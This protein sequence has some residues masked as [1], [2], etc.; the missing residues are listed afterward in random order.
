MRAS[1]TLHQQIGYAGWL[2]TNAQYQGEKSALRRRWLELSTPVPLPFL[3]NLHDGPA[4]AVSVEQVRGSIPLDAATSGFINDLGAFLRR[5]DIAQLVTWDLPLAQGPLS[6]ATLGLARGLLG[7]DQLVNT[8]PTWTDAPSHIDAR[9]DI[10]E[11]QQ[12]GAR[13]RGHTEDYPL[14]NL[15]PRAN[16]VSTLETAFRMWV[17]EVTVRRRYG[18]PRG[19][20]SRL[21]G[22]FTCLFE[23][24][25]DRVNQ[26]RRCYAAFLTLDPG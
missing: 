25:L 20:V 24:G 19:L 21:E 22:A 4:L 6:A 9:Q 16:Q 2:T 14:T 13:Q 10:R 17:I 11:T 26:V 18:S 3:A 5:W 15:G 1:N 7:P 8:S 12:L 23:F